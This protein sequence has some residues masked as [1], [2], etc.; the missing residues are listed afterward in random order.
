MCKDK[1]V[2]RGCHGCRDK[3]SIAC[4]EGKVYAPCVG[5]EADFPAFSSLL[6]ENDS[7]ITCATLDD[8]V[9]DIYDIL[10]DWQI[11]LSEFDNGCIDFG[12]IAELTPEIIFQ[13]HNDVLCNHEEQLEFLS[14]P[15]NIL[16]MDITACGLDLTCIQGQ[17]NCENPIPLNNLK[18]VLQA[19]INK[20]CP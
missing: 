9:K 14:N 15:C 17:D 3:V 6:D 16:D 2:K 19:L 10:T 4:G 5:V 7:P 11:D 18:D 13:K 1:K 12:G 8:V 20:N